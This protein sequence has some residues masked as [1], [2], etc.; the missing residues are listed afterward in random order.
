MTETYTFYAMNHSYYSGKVRPYLRYK[1]IPYKEVL[2]T[3]WVYKRFIE[4]RTGVRMIPVLQ[5]P[6]D[7]V[8]Q[9][10]TE[11]ID[12]LEQRFP[13]QSI[14]PDT[15]RQRLTC[16]LF[17]LFADEWLL[18]PAMHYRWS[19]L[20]E[21]EKWMMAEF[22]RVSGNW[23]PAPLRRIMGRQ[24]AKHFHAFLGPLGINAQT[25]PAIESLYEHFLELLNTHFQ[26]QPYLL[27]TRP[28]MG[29][30]ALAGPLYAHL[31]LDPYP[32]T[33]MEQRAPAVVDWIQRINAEPQ[34]AGRFLPDDEV[35][36]TLE[37]LLQMIFTEHFPILADTVRRLPGWLQANPGKPHI[38]RAIGEHEFSINGVQSK[39]LVFPYSQWMLQ[40]PLDYYQGADDKAR[41]DMDDWLE[42]VGG[43]QAM[44]LQIPRRVERRN[45]RLVAVAP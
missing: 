20:K 21:H 25:A 17:E 18:F 39:R 23:L 32:H 8:V 14:Y 16:L 22:G 6:D 13:E 19:Y 29:D 2:S 31:W 36:A 1:G 34:P 3:L 41:Q 24:V 26:Q 7:I 28:S 37:P 9:D 43:R 35:P 33:L 38:S 45:N 30:F 4:P 42:R 11:I 12:F 27:G 15:P 5:T 10:T 40:R 44:Q